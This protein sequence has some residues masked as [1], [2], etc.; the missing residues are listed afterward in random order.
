MKRLTKTNLKK[1]IKKYT[2]ECKTTDEILTQIADDFLYDAE[3]ELEKRLNVHYSD[4]W[5]DIIKEWWT[6]ALLR[7]TL[8]NAHKD[9]VKKNLIINQ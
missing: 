2:G 3:L 9:G 7:K 6:L 5:I 1:R 4:L 8:K